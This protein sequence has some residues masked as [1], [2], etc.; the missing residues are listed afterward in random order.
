MYTTRRAPLLLSSLLSALGCRAEIRTQ[1]CRTASRRATIFATP[2][3][4]W[5]KLWCTLQLRGQ[6]HSLYFSSTHVPP[7]HKSSGFQLTRKPV[8]RILDILVQIRTVESLPLTSGSS[9]GSFRKDLQDANT[10]LIFSQAFFAYYP[11]F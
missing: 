1:A 8:F 2:H 10:K 9:S 4:K 11:T 5:A 7:P 6:V 3:P